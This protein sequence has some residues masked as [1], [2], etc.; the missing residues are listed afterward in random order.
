MG[1]GSGTITGV[2]EGV[3]ARVSSAIGPVGFS[4]FPPIGGM[5]DI[6]EGY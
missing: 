6:Q 1:D 4:N 2:W 5:D 3:L